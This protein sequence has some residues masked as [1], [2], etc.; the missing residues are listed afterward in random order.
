M[1]ALDRV[2]RKIRFGKRERQEYAIMK[3]EVEFKSLLTD[4]LKVKSVARQFEEH[5][6]RE[7]KGLDSRRLPFI[8]AQIAF[9]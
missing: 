5:V 7:K 4:P 2:Q 1:D 9:I 6:A 3:Q 8:W